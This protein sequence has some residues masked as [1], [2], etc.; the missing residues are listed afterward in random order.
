MRILA[1]LLMLQQSPSVQVYI[2][3]SRAIE[4]ARRVARDL[5]FDIA[6]P[7]YY[8][9]LMLTK[10]G[11]PP[12]EGYVWVG[13]FGHDNLIE[14]FAISENTGQ[15]VEPAACQVFEFSNLV[16]LQRAQQRQSGLRS[17]TQKELMSDFG[18]DRLTVVRS[19]IIVR[20]RAAKGEK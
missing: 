18:F 17:K 12:V 20:S 4:V 2:P 8:F 1:I 13:F 7:E 5:G 9:D 11:R 19:P 16:P 3:T 14:T 10:D 6:D 15:V